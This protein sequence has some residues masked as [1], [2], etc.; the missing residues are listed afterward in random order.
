MKEVYLWAKKSEKNGFWQ[1]MSL[2]QH[3]V[4]TKNIAGILWEN[5]L[6]S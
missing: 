4:D 3:L 1:W 6:S 5:W 2:Y